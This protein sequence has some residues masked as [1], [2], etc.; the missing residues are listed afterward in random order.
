MNDFLRLPKL[1]WG[2]DFKA[3]NIHLFFLPCKETHSSF[4]HYVLAP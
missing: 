1:E 2:Y 3:P 4:K